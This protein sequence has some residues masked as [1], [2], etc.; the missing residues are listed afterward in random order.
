[1][2]HITIFDCEYLTAEG[3]MN[4]RW[5]GPHDPDPCVA[6]IGSVK[7]SLEPDFKV[8]DTQSLLIR[9]V[10]R[11]GKYTGLDPYF[12]NLTGIDST[13]IENEGIPLKEALEEFDRFSGNSSFWSWGK[14]ELNLLAISCYIA[15][16][17][18]V[19]PAHRF[20]N[21]MELLLKA[22]IARE[23]VLKTTSGELADYFKLT[24]L[25]RR[26]HDALDDAM[27]IALSLQH[28][29]LKGQLSPEDFFRPLPI[30]KSLNG[31]PAQQ[32]ATEL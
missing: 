30:P 9:T 2:S 4:N 23:D 6:Q 16:I 22:G 7:L 5:C 13:Q 29:L 18:P 20:G 10:D 1:M 15:E 26:H 8:L 11:L 24:G 28:L 17:K 12:T 31:A 25:P 27:S 19:I 14:D 3:A 32:S 21:A